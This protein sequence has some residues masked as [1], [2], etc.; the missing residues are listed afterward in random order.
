MI[1]T[2]Y[3]NY[4]QKSKTFLFPILGIRKGPKTTPLQTYISW[5]DR[6]TADQQKLLCM[7]DTTD[8]GH[9]QIE[10]KVLFTNPLFEGVIHSIT[11]T[12]SVYI[13]NISVFAEDYNH[14]LK[15]NYS[16]FSI[17][18]KEYIINYFGRMSPEYQFIETFLFPE[19]FYELYASLLDVSPELLAKV[20]ELTDIFDPLKEN[21]QMITNDLE[22]LI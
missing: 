1:T 21:L 4:F 11:E 18:L 5:E 17:P 15:G 10:Q 9:A 14:F 19:N 12:Q 8:P 16:K 13:F 7:Y 2:L 22:M 20:G 6:I 3:K